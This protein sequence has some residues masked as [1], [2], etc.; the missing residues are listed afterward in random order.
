MKDENLA[1]GEA[2]TELTQLLES[3]VNREISPSEMKK[4]NGLLKNDP[5]AR[6]AYLEAMSFEAAVAHEFPRTPASAGKAMESPRRYHW[7][8]F[9][10]AACVILSAIFVSLDFNSPQGTPAVKFAPATPSL[11]SLG[12]SPILSVTRMAGAKLRSGN[13]DVLEGDQVNQGRL[14]LIEGAVEL[15]FHSGAVMQLMAPA[16]ID[17]ES[18]FRAYILRGKA[19][20]N[21][22]AQALGFVVYTPTAFIRDLGS[23]FVV[24][25]F[26]DAKTQLSV[27]SGL[28]EVSASSKRGLGKPRRLKPNISVSMAGGKIETMPSEETSEDFSTIFGSKKAIPYHHWSLNE[29]DRSMTRDEIKGDELKFTKGGMPVEPTLTKGKFGRALHFDGRSHYAISSYPG[30]GGSE[31]RSL[32]FWVR[33]HPST[34]RETP[35][36]I[37]SWGAPKRSKKWQIAWNAE[38]NRGTLGAVRVEF[39]DGFVIG[40]TDLRNGA[41]HHVAVVFLGGSKADVS[42]HVRIYVDG[43]LETLSHREQDFSR[44]MINTEVGTP[45]AEPLIIGKYLGT[46]KG[47]DPFYFEGAIDELFVC[48]GVLQP[49]QIVQIMEENTLE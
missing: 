4:L 8:A 3:L 45:K 19:T 42:T 16:E 2:E 29:W 38:L 11:E 27:L 41:W 7:M 26:E 21:V 18:A 15:T 43:V 28:V 13:I 22:P 30:I 31:A 6:H 10:A 34:S 37:V 48:E 40:S 14:S 12:D 20:I 32:A 9:A 33:I 47:R 17:M 49:A 5:A 39:G 1:P 36:G 24:E 46:W 25:V 23:S 35:N 44:S